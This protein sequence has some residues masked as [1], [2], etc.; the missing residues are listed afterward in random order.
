MTCLLEVTGLVKSFGTRRVVDDVS[1]QLDTGQTLGLIGPNG[2][3]KSTT[4]GMVCGLIA[5]DAGQVRLGGAPLGHGNSA[6]KRQ[7][8]LVPQDLALYEDLSARENLKLFGALYGMKGASLKA[9]CDDVLKLVNLDNRARDK[10]RTFSGGM[11]R[12][13]NIAAA[14][15]HDPQLL[16]LDEPT[17]GVDPQSRNAIFD[18]LDLLRRQGRSL[19]YTS[20]YMEEVERLADRIVIIDYGKVIADETPPALYARLPAHAVLTINL[21][22][23]PDEALLQRLRERVGVVGVGNADHGGGL[24]ITLADG[25]HALPVLAWLAAQGCSALHFSTAKTSLE[26]IF[27]NMTGR[28]LRD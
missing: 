8:G 11:K 20:H 24:R 22:C 2:A 9:R 16:I 26:D 7:L 15:L 4:V 14:L 6:A 1:F 10:A 5:A 27:L 28:T 23:L 13:L 12:R 21:A 19:I 17:V 3:G 18:S 25:S